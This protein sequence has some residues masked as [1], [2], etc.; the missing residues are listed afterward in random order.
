MATCIE[1][2]EHI[3]KN[4]GM[5][6]LNALERIAKM[7]VITAPN[8][9]FLQ[10]PYDNNPF[11]RHVSRWWVK[12][13]T[14]RCYKVRGVGNFKTLGRSVKYF[15]FFLSRFSYLMLEFSD[16]L[17]AHK[18]CNKSPVNQLCQSTIGHL[19]KLISVSTSE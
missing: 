9:S 6:L 19:S 2:I 16:T 1:V 14:K 7:V 10:K 12:D 15:F 18:V 5:R 3:S 17:L 11:Q 13:F 8:V 4:K